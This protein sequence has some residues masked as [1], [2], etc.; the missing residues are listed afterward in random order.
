MRRILTLLASLSTGWSA[1]LPTE[2][3]GAQRTILLTASHVTTCVDSNE[4]LGPYYVLSVPAI[5]GIT[6]A[7]VHAA[8]LEIVFAVSSRD[9]GYDI[10]AALMLEVYRTTSDVRAGIDP[11]RLV[12]PSPMSRSIRAGENR[13]VRLD[14]TEA[15]RQYLREPE[16]GL[17]LAIGSLTESR[18]G[19]FALRSGV[20]GAGSLARLTIVYRE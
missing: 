11:Q 16:G 8:S 6:A 7:S 12:R 10:D 3:V 19:V 20:L 15:I 13:R 14:V 2:A 4:A 1:L 18:R 5:Q 9:P 17:E